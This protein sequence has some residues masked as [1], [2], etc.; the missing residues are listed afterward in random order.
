ME[1]GKVNIWGEGCKGL[2]K[3]VVR[4]EGEEE[5]VEKEQ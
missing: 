3:V 1:G 5:E 4:E 2:E